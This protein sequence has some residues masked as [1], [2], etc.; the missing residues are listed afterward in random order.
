MAVAII[1][2]E[3]TS[4]P[5]GRGRLIALGLVVIVTGAIYSF[6]YYLGRSGEVLFTGF[7]EDMPQFTALFISMYRFIGALVLIGLIPYWRLFKSRNIVL[8]D[9]Q[10]LISYVIASLAISMTVLSLA[11]AAMYAPI[12]QMGSVTQ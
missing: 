7:G 11:V 1:L 4:E 9:N 5:I 8:R 6:V 2:P 12:F 10:R 3:A